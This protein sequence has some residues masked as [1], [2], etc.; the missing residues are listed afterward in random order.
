M[1]PIQLEHLCIFL[2]Q[3]LVKLFEPKAANESNA[4][5]LNLTADMGPETV[6]EKIL[7]KIC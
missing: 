5:A 1:N 6:V 3:N 4:V 7:Q 2:F